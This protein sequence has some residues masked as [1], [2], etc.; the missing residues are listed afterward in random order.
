[1]LGQSWNGC[2]GLSYGLPFV[3][4]YYLYN[5]RSP[6]SHLLGEIVNLLLLGGISLV[7]RMGFLFLLT[8]SKARMEWEKWLRNPAG[9]CCVAG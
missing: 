3:S 4:P 7:F 6:L 5:G 2:Y 8:T 1:M 9:M